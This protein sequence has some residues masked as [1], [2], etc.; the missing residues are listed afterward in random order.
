M[1]RIQELKR[2][3]SLALQESSW[4][5]ALAVLEKL[6]SVE[7]SQPAYHNQMGDILLKSGRQAEA[8]TSFMRGI[9]AYR[10][11]GMYSNGAALCKKVLRL[12]PEQREAI[13]VLGE[14]K[15]RQG[16]LA[17]G[18]EHMLEGLKLY[19]E[20]DPMDRKSVL[21]LL[22]QA[23]T[24][25]AG[26]RE[27]LSYV[28]ST[29]TRMG[30]KEL[31]RKATLRMADLE[32]RE[33]HRDRAE[34]LRGEAR[35]MAPAGGPEPAP[36]SAA[37]AAPA[38]PVLEKR[39]RPS[40]PT[41]EEMEKLTITS[42][43]EPL[44]LAPTPSAAAGGNGGEKHEDETAE[45]APEPDDGFEAFTVATPADTAPEPEPES[46]PEPAPPALEADAEP[47]GLDDGAEDD[48]TAALAESML[49]QLERSGL[50]EVEVLPSDGDDDELLTTRQVADSLVSQFHL[51]DSVELLHSTQG[52]DAPAAAPAVPAAPDEAGGLAELMDSRQGGDALSSTQSAPGGGS[53]QGDADERLPLADVSDGL[54]SDPGD[55]HA[56]GG[57]DLD[58]L[59][60]VSVEDSLKEAEGEWKRKAEDE[61]RGRGETLPGRE[62]RRRSLD[63]DSTGHPGEDGHLSFG[64]STTAGEALQT[65]DID[66]VLGEFKRRMKEQ[67]GSMA[68]EER[69]QLGVSY[70]EMGLFE[71]ALEEFEHTLEHKVLGQKTREWMARC[72][73]E[74]ERP[75]E[76][77]LLLQTRLDAETYPHKSMVELYYLLGEAYEMLKAWDLALDAFTKVYQLDSEFRDVQ[78]KL[79]KL[80]TA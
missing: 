4:D 20:D 15:T 72:L 73:L 58:G 42:P 21:T 9:H 59:E 18:A 37:P 16:F 67:M 12:E 29:Y 68:P 45:S 7:E 66:E 38:G 79:A 5:D 1:S 13:W 60:L 63:L 2:N 17:D 3:L 49:A 19:A 8:I 27:L 48:E 78:A 26:S 39:A 28:A 40:I 23:E 36:D 11:L 30:E 64:L 14:L 31:A 24:L 65:D 80:T 55:G 46:E 32:E 25:Q 47:V 41:A 34:A 51:D 70:M 69:Y 71:E 52:D 22:E 61:A 43:G 74:L 35:N 10:E 50:P 54:A 6:V 75:R 57:L 76:I 33:G 62:G 44:P 77:V 56:A 53:S